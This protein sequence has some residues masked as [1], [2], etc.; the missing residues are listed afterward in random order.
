LS[1]YK[2][3][4]SRIQLYGPTNFAPSINHVA[5]I[6]R[7]HT[8][9][10]QYFILLIITDGIITDM[11]QT[12][13][14]IVNASNLPLSIIIVGVGN[15][16]FD[17]MDEL[18]GD[19]V[20]LIAPDGRMAARDIVQFVPFRNFLKG[21]LNSHSAGL[22]LAKEVLAEVPEQFIGYMKANRIVPKPP[23]SNPTR[24][25]PPDPEMTIMA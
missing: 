21:G 6:A 8:D 5:G 3:C 13:K 15:A 23:I 16:D 14:D 9:G 17:A 2:G 19:T 7:N 18:D 11:P 24:I 22:Y 20:R 12:K 25:E 10:S 4:I 1:A